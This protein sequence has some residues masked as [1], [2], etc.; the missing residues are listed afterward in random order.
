MKVMT[1]SRQ[2]NDGLF[3]NEKSLRE[4]HRLLRRE[5][6]LVWNV[7]IMTTYYFYEKLIYAHLSEQTFFKN[8]IG[9]FY[10]LISRLK[11]DLIKS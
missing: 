4:I 6:S 1:M 3:R 10:C 5:V 7:I 9:N 11:G 2:V 8:L